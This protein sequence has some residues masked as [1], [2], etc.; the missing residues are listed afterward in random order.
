MP[1]P[2]N[3]DSELMKVHQKSGPEGIAR[4]SKIDDE[5]DGKSIPR[6]TRNTKIEQ[7]L[8]PGSTRNTPGAPRAASN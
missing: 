3:I 8:F 6:G 1:R 7:K 2:A 5:I 4:A